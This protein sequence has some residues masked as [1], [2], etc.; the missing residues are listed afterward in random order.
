MQTLDNDIDINL[1]ETIKSIELE[2]PFI[3][4]IGGK[5]QII[6]EILNEIP[7]NIHTYHEIFLGGGSVLLGILSLQSKGIIQINN[8]VAY[9]I[10]KPLIYVYKNI[11][12]KP[13]K[14]LNRIIPII[15]EFNEIIGTDVNRKPTNLEEAKT[16]K[17]S[18][19]YWIRK[20]YNEM[21]ED[22]KTTLLGS[23]YFIF[24]NKT[25]FRG[26]YRLG[27]TKKDFNV[28]Y[29]NYQNPTIINST[30]IKNVSAL[31]RDVKFKH[32]SFEESLKKIKNNDVAFLDPPYVPINST[33][34]FVG[35]TAD[36]F[37][38]SMHQQL[39]NMLKIFKE[40]N[41]KWIMTNS[42]TAMV[43]D[44][45]DISKYSVKKILCRRAINSMKPNSSVNEVIIKSF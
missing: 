26:M 13:R 14:F 24:L 22:E 10:N 38:N 37:D 2:K 12:K 34:S 33:S 7:N 43:L 42:D 29:G 32:M 23:A 31:I 35:Y 27:K 15:N 40:Q 30:H 3:K 5:T 39:F 11:Q 41:K 19:Y 36:G 17:E 9:D 1:I 25:C 28:P 21:S 8:I 6:H 16:S 18:Y 45:F 20:K 44:N 4:W